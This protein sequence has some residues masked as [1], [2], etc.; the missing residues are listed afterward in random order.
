MWFRLSLSYYAN[1]VLV[2]L[3]GRPLGATS[4]GSGGSSG[5][6]GATALPLLPSGSDWM[7]WES[8]EVAES[9]GCQLIQ[10]APRVTP[11]PSMIQGKILE[12][13]EGPFSRISCRGNLHGTDGSHEGT[14][15]LSPYSR[16][17]RMGTLNDFTGELPSFRKAAGQP[18][19]QSLFQILV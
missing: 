9:C 17:A 18:L 19:G 10:S 5:T 4:T 11:T 2:R 8:F 16:G 12:N 6:S 14:G 7:I 15:K 3:A 13:R 1:P